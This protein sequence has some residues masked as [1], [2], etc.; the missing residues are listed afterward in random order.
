MNL[1][2]DIDGVIANFSK[3]LLD[4]IKE[5]YGLTLQVM[6]IYTF[7]LNIVLGI[8]KAEGNQLITETLKKDLPLNSGAKETLEQLSREGHSIYL[9]TGRYDHLRDLTQSWLKEKG[10]PYNQLHLLNIGEKYLAKVDPLDLIVED[11]LEE[12]LEWT[13]KVRNVLV[14]DQPW[15]KTFQQVKKPDYVLKEALRVGGRVIVGFPNFVN[16]SSRA[17]IFFKGRVPVTK[18]LPY[19]WYDTP[20]LHFLGIADFKEYCKKRGIKIEASVFITKKGRVRWFANLFADVGLFLLS[21]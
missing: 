20:N 14:Y 10:V 11:S 1:G 3:P 12:A 4:T 9:L 15:N 5:K 19:E 7:D 8:T 18:S 2:F 6:D 17:Q 13:H 16:L 21:A